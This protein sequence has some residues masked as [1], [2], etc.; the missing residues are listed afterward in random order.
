[1]I[2]NDLLKEAA[3]KQIARNKERLKERGVI[4]RDTEQQS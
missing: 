1:M 3:Q 4:F 2:D